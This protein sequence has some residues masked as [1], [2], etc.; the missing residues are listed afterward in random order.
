MIEERPFE[1][2]AM[3]PERE[4][5]RGEEA[6]PCPMRMEA[7]GRAASLSEEIEFGEMREEE[8]A[9]GRIEASPEEERE[10]CPEM[11]TG[12][13]IEEALPTRI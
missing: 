2:R 12:E 4:S 10:K 6:G 8:M 7:E 9:L 3:G 11:G 13:G 1:L 5:G